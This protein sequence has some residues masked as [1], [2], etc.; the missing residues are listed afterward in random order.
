[1][2][3][4][5]AS[6]LLV[7]GVTWYFGEQRVKMPDAIGS[8]VRLAGAEDARAEVAAT[9]V[10]DTSHAP[11]DAAVYQTPSGAQFTVVALA[12]ESAWAMRE[13]EGFAEDGRKQG[14]YVSLTQAR[15]FQ[16]AGVDFACAP[17]TT[18][19]G[20]QMCLWADGETTGL[21]ISTDLGWKQLDRMA[22]RAQAA[23]GA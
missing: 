5:I 15:S 19:L 14:I 7:G 12:I 2:R 3:W 4:V 18:S 23:V 20:S 16:A 1:M 11:A 21:V 17:V 10:E 6:T 13:L 22:V 9:Q 8:A